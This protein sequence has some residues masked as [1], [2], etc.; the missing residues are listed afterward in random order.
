M[1]LLQWAGEEAGD[2]SDD[3]EEEEEEQ[4]GMSCVQS[5]IICIITGLFEYMFCRRRE[6]M[7][8]KQLMTSILKISHLLQTVQRSTVRTQIDPSTLQQMWQ[9]ASLP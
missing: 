3:D 4:V 9:L 6:L 1:R 7:V 8:M 5:C 2:G